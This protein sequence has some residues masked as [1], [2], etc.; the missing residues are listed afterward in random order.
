MT[1]T[2]DPPILTIPARRRTL[3][4]APVLIRIPAVTASSRAPEGRAR[5]RRLRREVRVAGYLLLAAL[6]L[7]LA[8]TS[9]GGDRRPA[10]AA[11]SPAVGVEDAAANPAEAMP[12]TISISLEPVLSAQPRDPSESPVFLS[13][14][15]LPAEVSPEETT[16]GRR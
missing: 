5:R 11:T 16:H 10:L 9:L 2:Q 15:L 14:Q 6:P 8:Y 12:P 3:P 4:A 7:S 1:Q 13:G